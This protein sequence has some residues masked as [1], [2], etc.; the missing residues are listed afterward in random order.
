MDNL[1]PEIKAMVSV[2]SAL[3][4]LDVDAQARVVRW[5][6]EKYNVTPPSRAA[7]I[8]N[9]SADEDDSG[10]APQFDA[11][12]DLYDAVNPDTS[13][14]KVLVG[15]YWLQVIQ[16]ESSWSSLQVNNLLKD[17]GNGVEGINHRLETA[18]SQKPALVRQIS[19]TGKSRQGRKSYKLTT[20]GI[21]LVA[22]KA[23]VKPSGT[24]VAEEA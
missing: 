3:D 16:G 21:N 2:S 6:A 10:N 13:V 15:A 24:K 7:Q 1:D 8:G 23:G 14:E 18:Q 4:G 11:F 5:A 17:T 9:Q 19:K 22:T 20:A 12:V